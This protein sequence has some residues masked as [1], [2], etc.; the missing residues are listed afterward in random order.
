M[1]YRLALS[2]M[3]GANI[4]FNASEV[5]SSVVIEPQ[6]SREETR[7]QLEAFLEKNAIAHRRGARSTEGVIVIYS[8]RR[9]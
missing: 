1:G 9:G 6:Q 2:Q 4:A 5:I 3:R 7:I 8:T